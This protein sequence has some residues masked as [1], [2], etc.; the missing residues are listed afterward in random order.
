MHCSAIQ[1]KQ[2]GHLKHKWTK[3]KLL[4]IFSTKLPYNL[5]TQP[6]RNGNR[7]QHTACLWAEIFDWFLLP[8]TCKKYSNLIMIHPFYYTTTHTFAQDKLHFKL[9]SGLNKTL[10]SKV[11]LK[12]IVPRT[13]QTAV[14]NVSYS[15]NKISRAANNYFSGRFRFFDYLP[16]I[17]STFFYQ[18]EHNLLPWSTK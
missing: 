2:H 14:S 4:F 8:L 12:A 10:F 18:L 15:W 5:Y 3:L 7:V 11:T 6:R 13:F 17:P 1:K 9:K 16:P